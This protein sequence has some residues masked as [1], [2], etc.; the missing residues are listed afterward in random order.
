M[1]GHILSAAA[2]AANEAPDTETVDLCIITL[3][4]DAI[5]LYFSTQD[6]TVASQPYIGALRS[7]PSVVY[8]EGG[9]ADSGEFVLENASN[10]YGPT[11]LITSRRLDGGKVVIRRAWKIA[12]VW[13]QS[14][15]SSEPYELARGTIRV[16]SI[17]DTELKC[18]FVNDFSDDSIEIGGAMIPQHCPKTFNVGG[19]HSLGGPCGWVPAM[20]GNPNFCNKLKNHAEGCSGHG[21]TRHGGV[22]PMT[23]SAS[24]SP[25]ST[26]P[27]V[28]PGLPTIEPT[29]GY[30][31]GN[32]PQRGPE[33]DPDNRFPFMLPY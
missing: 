33:L 13:Q 23:A 29:G 6:V 27:G 31:G 4:D 25:V 19:N 30:G 7:E 14:T 16:K 20:G 21:N 17:S 28:A 11:F 2:T 5:T 9:N 3:P 8:S 1:G 32:F 12:G 10:S 24:V 22:S 15:E 18:S 26:G